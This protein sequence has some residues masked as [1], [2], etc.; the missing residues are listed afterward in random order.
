MR[1]ALF[2]QGH[3]F[4]IK[5]LNIGYAL[6]HFSFLVEWGTDLLR[7]LF[8]KNARSDVFMENDVVS[9]ILCSFILNE[10][11]EQNAMVTHEK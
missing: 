3:Y 9:V 11:V 4:H 8:Q 5:M 10:R 6:S 2:G 7:S 1:G